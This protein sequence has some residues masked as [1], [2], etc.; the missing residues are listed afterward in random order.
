VGKTDL[1]YDVARVYKRTERKNED[2]RDA[3][4]KIK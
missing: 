4:Q 3:T 2:V 1:C